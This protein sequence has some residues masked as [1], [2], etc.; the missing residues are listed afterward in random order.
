MTVGN[1]FSTWDKVTE[2]TIL[3]VIQGEAESFKSIRER[4][5]D[6]FVYNDTTVA[7]KN[8]MSGI[9]NLCILWKI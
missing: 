2:N 9:N 7:Q 6:I 1:F 8:K 5:V 4:S 3:F